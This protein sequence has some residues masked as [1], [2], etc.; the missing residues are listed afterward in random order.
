MLVR[1]RRLGASKVNQ[2]AEATPGDLHP[3]PDETTNFV[4]E[5]K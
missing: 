5:S 4:S 1:R 3:N 2:L